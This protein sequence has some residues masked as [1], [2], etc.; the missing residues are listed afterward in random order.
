LLDLRAVLCLSFWEIAMLFS[1]V[2]PPFYISTNS[3][4]GFQFLHILANAL[5]LGF[6]ILAILTGVRI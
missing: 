3:S 2:V 6:L 5:S 4:Q 1:I